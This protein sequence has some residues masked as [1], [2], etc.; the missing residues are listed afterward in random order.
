MSRAPVAED[1]REQVTLSLPR[2]VA[3]LLDPGVRTAVILSV[4]VLGGFALMTAGYYG[5]DHT[6]DIAQELPWL[7]SSGIG[8]LGLAGIAAAAL[9]AHLSRRDEAAS[10]HELATFARELRSTIALV[11]TPAPKK[12]ATTKTST[13][14]Q[15][16]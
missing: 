9:S 14:T 3:S 10:T 12:K 7:V 1:T 11:A 6:R 8:G 5:A 16:K 13:T 15:R 2:W 4:V